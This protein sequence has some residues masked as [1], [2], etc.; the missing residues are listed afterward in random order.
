MKR[1]LPFIIIAAVALVTVGVAAMLLRANERAVAEHHPS[2]APSENGGLDAAHAVGPANA[3]VT[4]EEYGD[5][6]C[7]ACAN[8][9]AMLST[10]EKDYH[11]R[12]RV[13]FWQFPLPVHSHGREAA[14]TAE[15]A[16]RQGRFWE[17]HHLLYENQAAWKN[18]PDVHD[19]FQK[20]AVQLQLNIARFNQDL[21]SPA[22]A[23]RVDAEHAQG[24]ARGVK[25]T[26]TLFVN[27]EEFPPPFLPER[28]HAAI[29]SALAD[30]KKP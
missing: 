24:E 16:S 3:K 12:L 26:P 13:I 6:Q 2:P 27:G 20:F 4:I 14:L 29:D 17:M 15:A 22:V 23:A 25:A 5:F 19:E 1:F 10:L 30:K 9:A 8:V 28:L 7:P 21:A 18:L 11:D